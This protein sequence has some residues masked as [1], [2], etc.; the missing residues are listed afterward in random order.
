MSDDDWCPKIRKVFRLSVEEF[1]RLVRTLE[2]PPRAN[3]KLK[4]L[5][6]R[7]PPWQHDKPNAETVA[8]LEEAE[9]KDGELFDGP[10]SEMIKGSSDDH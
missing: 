4:K 1:N 10:T 8:A 7:K 5:M 2:K 6:R 9:R 3:G